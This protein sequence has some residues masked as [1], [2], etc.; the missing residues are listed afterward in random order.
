MTNKIKDGP[1]ISDAGGAASEVYSDETPT[2]FLGNPV[3]IS[4]R[5]RR[6]PSVHV[7]LEPRKGGSGTAPFWE[8]GGQ[9]SSHCCRAEDHYILVMNISHASVVTTYSFG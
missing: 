6:Q 7:D 8:E 5:K 9:G 1:Y 4:I 2:T 3:N